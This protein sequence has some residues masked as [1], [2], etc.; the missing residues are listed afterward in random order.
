VLNE[1]GRDLHRQGVAGGGWLRRGD[2]C[3][4]LV[5]RQD[6]RRRLAGVAAAVVAVRIAEVAVV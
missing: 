3:G 4:P 5:H 1:V 6:R 2:C